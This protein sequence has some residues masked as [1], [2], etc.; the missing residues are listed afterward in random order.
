MEYFHLELVLVLHFPLISRAVPD[1]FLEK[2]V[3]THQIGDQ[4]FQ[5]LDSV[6]SFRSKKREEYQAF[7]R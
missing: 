2:L 3:F 4:F 1:L 6:Y 7:L 5:N